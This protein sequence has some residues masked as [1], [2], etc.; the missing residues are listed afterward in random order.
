MIVKCTNCNREQEYN[1]DNKYCTMCGNLLPTPTK[2]CISCNK[3]LPLEANFCSSCGT[4]QDGILGT[5]QTSTP[6]FH[7][8][9]DNNIA[10]DFNVVG[11]KEEFNIDGNATII[12]NADETKQ[13]KACHICGENK[14][15]LEGHNCKNCGKFTC[16]NCF[17]QEYLVCNKCAKEK[18]Q[19]NED[20][21]KKRLEFFLKDGIIDNRGREEL[22]DLQKELKISNTRALSLE[23]IVK[24]H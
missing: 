11:K 24:K 1:E 10:G 6:G 18:I 3:E 9:N 8:G 17:N 2:K 15:I 4:K 22:N 21:F 14:T 12:K 20:K 7:M 13:V 16:K 23:N 19:V 5:D